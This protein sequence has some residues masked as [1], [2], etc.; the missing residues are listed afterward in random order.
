MIPAVPVVVDLAPTGAK[1][2][3]IVHIH[4]VVRVVNTGRWIPVVGALLVVGK[5][6]RIEIPTTATTERHQNDQ[7]RA[8]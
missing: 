4:V 8:D 7:K 2:S 1:T 6:I 5:G 3:T